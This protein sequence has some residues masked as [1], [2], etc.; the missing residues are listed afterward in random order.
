MAILCSQ[1]KA[2][3]KFSLIFCIFLTTAL[4][5]ASRQ[6]S[7][8]PN[9]FGKYPGDALWSLMVYFGWALLKPKTQPIKIGLYALMTSFLIEFA[10]LI[11]TPWLNSIRH[12][13]LGHLLL[14]TTFSP[15]DLAAY[16]IGLCI[17]YLLDRLILFG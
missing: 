15:S 5:L 10:Q 12:T 13:T 2:R 8:F 4:G 3:S 11:Q 7:L 1:T 16:S 14:G 9:I 17:G 6:W